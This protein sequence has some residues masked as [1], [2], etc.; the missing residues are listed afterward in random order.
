MANAHIGPD[1]V[2]HTEHG[3]YQTVAPHGEE[4]EGEEEPEKES[5]EV[6]GLCT[7]V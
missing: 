3:V 7:E 1:H 2:I 4:E 6:G 5:V